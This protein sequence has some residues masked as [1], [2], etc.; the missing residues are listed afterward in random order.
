MDDEQADKRRQDAVGFG[1]DAT[2]DATYHEKDDSD[3][4]ITTSTWTVTFGGEAFLQIRELTA[5]YT[6]NTFK[7]YSLVRD[8]A[9]N[10]SGSM[11]DGTYETT[12]VI[13]EE[14]DDSEDEDEDRSDDRV[15]R[16]R[17]RSDD[18]PRRSP[19]MLTDIWGH[20][21]YGDIEYLAARGIAQGVIDGA[22]QPDSP[23]TRAQFLAL[24]VRALGLTGGA[25]AGV[26]FSDVPAD[27]WAFETVSIALEKGLIEGVGNGG[28]DP[29][30][31]I[32][33]QEMAIMLAR[34]LEWAGR[35]IGFGDPAA[36]LADLDDKDAVASWATEAVAAVKNAGLM[37]GRAPGQFDPDG[38]ATR[39][40][41]ATVI[42]RLM[43]LLGIR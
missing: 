5:Q 36:A 31:E 9:G 16:S 13:F 17:K 15:S 6:N 11:N 41:A 24:M 22:F 27:H 26:A 25:P 18:R 7:I 34:A 28:F 29:D 40:E 8:K 4:G 3:T 20:W 1:M 35:A 12:L 10:Q 33:R 2:Y 42:K 19:V 30:R 32:T 37:K 21:A 23:V 38:I 14:E 43:D 39:A